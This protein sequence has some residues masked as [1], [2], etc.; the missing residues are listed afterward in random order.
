MQTLGLNTCVMKKTLFTLLVLF[1][2]VFNC[3]GQKDIFVFATYTYADNNRMKHIEPLAKWLSERIG[4]KF[5][6]RSYPTVSALIQAIANDS[7]NFAMM[8]TSGYLT[9]QKNYPNVAL[10]LINLDMGNDSSTNYGGC[11]IA[12]K[13]TGV[14]TISDLKMQANRLPVALVSSS[15]TSGNLVPRLLM[16]SIG[17]SN[18]DSLFDVYYAGTHK[19]VTE[20][21][22]NGKAGIGGC[23][24]AEVDKLKDN[25]AFNQKVAVISLF[26]N[27]PLGPIV[28][29]KK[30]NAEIVKMISKE[31][32]SVHEHD[33]EV[34]INFCEGW[35]EFRQA[36]G[37]RT[38]ADSDYDTF[39][40]MFGN[41]EALWKLIE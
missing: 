35:T 32:L 18:P 12:G 40:K 38:V 14:N 28:F 13:H 3:A 20:D 5:V 22:M 25:T 29:S 15:S 21:V 31:L 6:A 10:P 34:F 37:F 19:Q 36:K 17:I 27:I 1:T 24:C 16:N 41:N 2:A 26:N 33:R 39:R 11:I 7:V 4:K 8:N 9:L 30:T 23:G